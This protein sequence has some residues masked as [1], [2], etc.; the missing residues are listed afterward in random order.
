MLRGW[1]VQCSSTGMVQSFTLSSLPA[2][3]PAT[4]RKVLVTGAAGNIGSYFA[5]HSH[6]RYDLRLMEREG[7][8]VDA[9]KKFGEIVHGDVSNLDD[10]KRV[11][12]DVDTVLHLAADPSPS[13]VWDSLLHVN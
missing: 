1:H 13:A 10:M 8:A 2:S 7:E 9:I 12:R 5:E 6:E 3:R 11:C 4:G